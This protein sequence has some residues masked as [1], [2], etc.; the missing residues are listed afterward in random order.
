[1]N[2]KSHRPLDPRNSSPTR[3]IRW[4]VVLAMAVALV[5]MASPAPALRYGATSTFAVGDGPDDLVVH[6]LN[7]DGHL[8]VVTANFHGNSATVLLGNGAGGFSSITTY[9]VTTGAQEESNGLAI[10]DFDENG[11]PDIVLSEGGGLGGLF[12]FLGD[13]TGAF[14]PGTSFQATPGGN[15]SDVAAGDLNGDGHA[16]IVASNRSNTSGT[17]DEVS[18][19]LGRGDGTFEAS[20]AY[21]AGDKF[22]FGPL[23]IELADLDGDGDLDVAAANSNIADASDHL[24]VW[25]GNG[26]GTLGERHGYDG[27]L[28]PNGI[29]LG[30]VDADGDVDAV[31]A[32]GNAGSIS[33]FPNDGTGTF[34]PPSVIDFFDTFTGDVVIA[35]LDEDGIVDL[36]TGLEIENAVVVIKGNG[37]GTFS[38]HSR[39]TVNLP[40]AMAVGDFDEDGSPDIATANFEGD[41]IT[42]LLRP[43]ADDDDLSNA[44]ETALGTNPFD[45]DTDDDALTDGE[46]VVLGTDPL[47]ADTDNDAIGDGDEEALGTD[48]L[49]ADS[50]NDGLSDSEEGVMG[51]D[52]LDAD[53][54]DDGISDGEDPDGI[55]EIVE[56]LPLSAL[57]SGGNRNAMLVRLASIEENI[58]EGDI[59][60]ALSQL[61]NLRLRVDG[62]TPESPDPDSNDW[63]TDSEAQMQIRAMIDALIANLEGA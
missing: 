26:D 42:L 24:I 56:G 3:R 33:I 46:E 32:C 54:D 27:G 50:D 2:K 36:A 30:D 17:V 31:L 44:E 53:S 8:D 39:M 28:S 11:A 57:H 12:I 62:C 16:D 25:L 48:P 45:S 60:Q 37:D 20:V 35:D 18:V 63:I 5:T 7:G 38:S 19:H 34:G 15:P 21:S 23:D 6:D 1:M 9:P 29:A 41:N 58:S 43:D 10:A 40:R 13:G 49:D 61:R 14:T 52:P 55:T 47:D 59:D 4:V 51:T 22:T